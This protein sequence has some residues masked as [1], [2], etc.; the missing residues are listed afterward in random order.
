MPVETLE[1]RKIDVELRTAQLVDVLRLQQVAQAMLPEILE[2]V[3]GRKCRG[4]GAR[5]MRQEDLFSV[6]RPKHAR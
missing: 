6:P 5:R 2:R 4:Q 3:A 1:R